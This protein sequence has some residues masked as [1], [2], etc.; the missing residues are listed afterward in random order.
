MTL[1]NV[2]SSFWKRLTSGCCGSSKDKNWRHQEQVALSK[3]FPWERDSGKCFVLFNQRELNVY[4]HRVKIGNRKQGEPAQGGGWE[5]C[6]LESK[7]IT[8]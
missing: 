5:G 2:V 6:E 4:N 7:S 1:A 3:K 8:F